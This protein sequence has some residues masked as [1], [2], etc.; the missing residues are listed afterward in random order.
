VEGGARKPGRENLDPGGRRAGSG[1]LQG[2]QEL[3]RHSNHVRLHNFQCIFL[4]TTALNK[5][6]K[7]KQ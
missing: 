3:G 5:K 7:K 1:C 2:K 4:F 6:K